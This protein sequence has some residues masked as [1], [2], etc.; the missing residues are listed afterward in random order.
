MYHSTKAGLE[1]GKNRNLS[2][3][4]VECQ[5]YL[6]ENISTCPKSLCVCRLYFSVQVH[7]LWKSVRI[8]NNMTVV[9]WTSTWQKTL[10]QDYFCLTGWV[11]SCINEA[12]SFL[13]SGFQLTSKHVKLYKGIILLVLEAA[14][15]EVW[16]NIFLSLSDKMQS[17]VYQN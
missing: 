11:L 2:S 12:C 6:P 13:C 16:R 14:C 17:K 8:F 5:D 1:I 7:H 10:V 15:K 3:R 9:R 4:Q